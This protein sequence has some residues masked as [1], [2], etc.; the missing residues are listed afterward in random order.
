MSEIIEQLKLRMS[1]KIAWADVVT[2]VHQRAARNK[3]GVGL[4]VAEAR[5]L[6]P[7]LR[8]LT[9]QPAA[10]A[11]PAPPIEAD[12]RSTWPADFRLQQLESQV[13]VLTQR[14]N[15]MSAMLREMGRER[16]AEKHPLEVQRQ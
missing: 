12:D 7:V 15:T 9:E 14:C 10:A 16:S 11:S 2:D 13:D 6:L 8:R 4:S 5:E 3:S 1:E